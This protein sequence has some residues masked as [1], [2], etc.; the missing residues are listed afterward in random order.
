MVVLEKFH[1]AAEDIVGMTPIGRDE[2][3]F[4]EPCR[5]DRIGQ[6]AR[7]GPGTGSSHS[8]WSYLWV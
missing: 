2:D 4:E 5:G 3:E 1:L 8:S 6:V 7:Q